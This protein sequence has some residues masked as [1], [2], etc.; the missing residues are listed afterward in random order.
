MA[1]LFT[2]LIFSLFLSACASQ[3]QLAKTDDSQFTEIKCSGF[4][5]WHDCRKEAIAICPS[6]FLITNQLENI[7]I[8]RR[9]VSVACKS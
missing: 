2:S 9:E 4:L 6:G 3:T 8:Q 1:K 7:T 5:T